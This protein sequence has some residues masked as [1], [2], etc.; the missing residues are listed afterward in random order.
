MEGI[1]RVWGKEQDLCHAGRTL[2]YVSTPHLAA[3]NLRLSQELEGHEGCINCINF[4]QKGNLLASGSDDTCVRR[5]LLR[6][7][8]FLTSAV[9]C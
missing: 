1:G 5:L 3:A 7:G 4:N 2:R 8:M 9:F 6:S